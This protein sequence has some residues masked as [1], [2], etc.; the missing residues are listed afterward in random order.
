MKAT[1]LLMFIV[2]GL[3]ILASCTNEEQSVDNTPNI[4]N[5]VDT[6]NDGMI[7]LGEKFDNPYSIA[8]M[9]AVYN[10]MANTRSGKED[11]KIEVTDWYVRF[12]PKDST[13]YRTLTNDLQL[14]LFDYPLDHDVLTEG[15]GYHDPSIPEG[16]MT[17]QYTTVKPGF[18]FPQNIQYELIDECFIPKDEDTGE[19]DEDE[20][21]TRSND[22]SFTEELEY[23]AL[24]KVGYIKCL[25]KKGLIE[26]GARGLF[27]FLSGKKPKGYI[28]VYDTYLR[29]DVPVK[30]IKVRATSLIKWT[31]THT[32]ENG[33]Y[34][35]GSKH[36]W[37]PLY[38]V[39]FDNS[40]GFDI[41]GYSGPLT[42]CAIYIMG[43]HNKKGYDKTFGESSC[44]WE[45]ATVNNA[46]YDY[47]AKCKDYKTNYPTCPTT[48]NLKIWV[49]KG[50]GNSSASMIRRVYHPIGVN[51][52]SSWTNFF[53]NTI[54]GFHASFW[55]TVFHFAM[56]DITIGTSGKGSE[57]IYEHVNHE[58]SHASHFQNV[59][60]EFW[61]KYISYIITY[62]MYGDIT[63]NN[64]GICGVGEMWGYAMGY[65]EKYE[66]YY[67]GVYGNIPC[68]DKYWFKPEIIWDLYK[69][70]ILTKREIYNC[71][72]SDVKTHAQIKQ[73]MISKYPSK[74]TSIINIFKL[75]GFNE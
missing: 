42:G 66:K 60:S 53:T 40:Q 71:M 41:W 64:S 54:V 52:N 46:A 59:G 49:W 14:E 35:M 62:G 19:D 68:K 10:E 56:P 63:C 1:K 25:E 37:G 26:S 4:D 70:K 20:G 67:G 65:I 47:Y 8:N 27:S 3:L 36:Y 6:E 13:E 57:A 55:K 23:R 39:S 45:W 48:N 17:W 34:S 31:S 43:F 30:G 69:N 74:A 72:T 50:A 11:V 21:L 18:Q 9:T 29:K 16:Q 38:S 12:L 5:T 7:V 32:D 58:L 44:A 75:Y 24:E 61:A 28:K 33:Y 15:T 51:S 2:F 73:K 22:I